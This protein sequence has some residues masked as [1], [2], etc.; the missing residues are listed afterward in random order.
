MVKIQSPAQVWRVSAALTVFTVTVV[1]LEIILVYPPADQRRYALIAC[2]TAAVLT[3]PLATAM[4]W[5][6]LHHARLIDELRRLV[7][8]DRLTD[9]ATRDYF[10]TRMERDTEAY[11]V[12]LVVDIDHFKQVNDTY[13][14]LVGDLVIHDVAK[15]L[16]SLVRDRDIV[17]RFGGEEFVVFLYDTPADRG[18]RVAERMRAAI[19]AAEIDA[20]EVIVPVTVSIGGA[21]KEAGQPIHMA[22]H[23]AD[24]A[25]YR[26]K[27]DGR[28][29]T[30]MSWSEAE[31]A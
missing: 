8:R 26:A 2:G 14:H 27:T 28:N 7:N 16:R 4:G 1:L 24:M 5:L 30:V 3:F 21:L 11:G 13:G 25:L 29:R 15:I 23:S 10:F 20:G 6:I 9:A 12:S 18:A 19:A 31:A 17:C 22:I